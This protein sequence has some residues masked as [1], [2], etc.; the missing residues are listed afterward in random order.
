VP[1]GRFAFAGGALEVQGFGRRQGEM[2]TFR[3]RRLQELALP[4]GLIRLMLEI[5]ESKGRQQLYEKQAGRLLRALG[6]AALH[7]SI[8]CSTR[9]D[10]VTIELTRLLPLI[11]KN[12][13]PQSQSENEIRGYAQTLKL[14]STDAPNLR[15]T[16]EFLGRLHG[17]ILEGTADAE[18]W[19]EE[20]SDI[21]EFRPNELSGIP[22]RL[23]PVTEIPRAIDELCKSYNAV[24]SRQEVYP[25]LAVGALV[26]DFLCLH[27]FRDGNGRVSRLLA[28]LCLYQ[29]GFEI[30]RCISLE[31]LMENSR[32]DYY[33][34]LRKSREG[35]REGKHDLVPWLQYF[36][37]VLRL[38]YAEF[39]RRVREAMSPRGAM[40]VL[41]ET[42]VDGLPVEFTVSE[43]E[44]T[45][46]GV[47]HGM[48]CHVLA[49]LE[50]RGRLEHLG[51]GH[52]KSWRK[53][54]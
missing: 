40:T 32:A 41:V 6:A 26:L 16:P 17:I 47:S 38:A 18:Q 12:V 39:E 54:Y 46:P 22:F 23:V 4:P 37:G 53:K 9:M 34:A 52:G 30:G 20:E 45:C 33:V 2:M 42:A 24:L 14:I 10:G 8:E 35:W 50:K 48:I 19:R 25:L 43:L 29:N 28:L 3:N 27:P 1:A 36:F 15:V 51:R 21:I 13:R 5:A 11:T 49:E 31:H 44:R 7:Q